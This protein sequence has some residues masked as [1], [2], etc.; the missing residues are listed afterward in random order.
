MDSRKRV[1]VYMELQVNKYMQNE[2]DMQGQ[3]ICLLFAF[4]SFPYFISGQ[5]TPESDRGR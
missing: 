2:S 3:L 1:Q 4:Y 5:V